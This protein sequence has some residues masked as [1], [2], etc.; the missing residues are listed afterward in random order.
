[1]E[2][3]EKLRVSL[4]QVNLEWEDPGKN[5][6]YLDRL[7]KGLYK[8]SDLI[9]FPETF[10]TGFS[11]KAHDLAEKMDGPTVAWMQSMAAK[12][13]SAICGSLIINE[14]D[15][16]FNRFVFV[17]PQ[18]DIYHYDKRHLFSMGGEKNAFNCGSSRTIIN[19][20]GWRIALYICYDLRFPVWC[21]NC[22]DTDLMLFSANWPMTRN[23]AWNTLLKARAI[24]NQVYVAGINRIG[25]DG[26]GIKYM[27]ETQVINPTGKVILSPTFQA[28]G[29]LTSEISMNELQE[30]RKKFPVADDADS[31]DIVD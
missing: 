9:V 29:L 11:M 10:T 17:N 3:K 25:G 15:Q 4:A 26:N 19:H 30:F 13:N 1:M 28:G 31:F 12:S 16:Y 8:P 23:F 14:S 6:E 21:R 7:I 22:N 24:E 27:G 2:A 5:R 18:G 20:L